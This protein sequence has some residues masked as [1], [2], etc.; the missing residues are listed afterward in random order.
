MQ[1]PQYPPPQYPPPYQQGYPQAFQPPPQP[2][3]PQ[4]PATPPPLPRDVSVMDALRFST[5][6]SS[7]WTNVMFCGLLYLS[8]QIIPILGLIVMQGF[9][10][11]VHRRLVLRHPEPY[12]RFDFSDLS[13]YL[14]RGVAPFVM[15]LVVA[16]PFALVGIGLAV[17]VIV[18]A[19]ASASAAFGGDQELAVLA[20]IGVAAIG[21]L[22]FALL[23]FALSNAAVTRAEL[24]GD[25]SKSFAFGALWAYAA[26]TWKRVLV[27]AIIMTF[28]SFGL[29]IVGVLA[30][31]VG[32]F[33][34]MSIQMIAS[35]HLRWQIYN[36][37]L[38]EGG[39]PI[40]LALW[41]TLPS[42]TQRP[43]G[44]AVAPGP[45]PYGPPPVR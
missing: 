25:L 30:C 29:M 15:T 31:F 12:V 19:G 32:L 33:V 10:A 36:D 23:W 37:Y 28:V 21:F 26:K 43:P 16:L 39:E 27:T 7:G 41:E 18:L 24:T 20:G 42:E 44:H 9:F 6:G 14:S 8:T 40:E 4:P 45:G 13:N 3:K 1:P 38:L 34:T 17:G 35:L 22:P 2:P 11:E 5:S